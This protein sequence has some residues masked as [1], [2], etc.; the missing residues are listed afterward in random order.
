[1]PSTAGVDAS[2][3]LAVDADSE[4]RGWDGASWTSW[5]AGITGA[6]VDILRQ[7]RWRCP[8]IHAYA[9]VGPDGLRLRHVNEHAVVLPVRKHSMAELIL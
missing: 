5:T 9:F 4:P 8:S 7:L 1:M 6:G 3:H 2:R